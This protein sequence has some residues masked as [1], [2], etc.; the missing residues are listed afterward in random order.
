MKKTGLLFLALVLMTAADVVA[1]NPEYISPMHPW[2]TSDE[3]GQ[4][5]ICGMDLV[6]YDQFESGG[7]GSIIEIDPVVVQNLGVRLATAVRGDLQ[8]N[9]RTVGIV[10]YEE[11]GQTSVNSKISGWVEELHVSQTGQ[12]IRKGELLL[13]IYSPDLVSAQEEYLMAVRNYERL[14]HSSVTG[15]AE[16]AE[17]LLASAAQRLRYWDIS[18]QDIE[19]LRRSKQVRKTLPLYAPYDG[20]VVKK[21]VTQ[22]MFINAGTE[23]YQ[24]ADLSRVWVYADIYEHDL[25]WIAQGMAAEV[26]IPHRQQ[27]LPGT[28]DLLYPYADG[29]TRT[30]KAR[31]ALA[32]SDRALRPDMFVTVRLQ[33]RTVRNAVLVPT[34]AIL[35]SGEQQRVFV[36]LGDGRF[37][38]RPVHTG[39]RGSDGLVEVHGIDAGEQVVVSAQFMLDSESRLREAI[40]KMRTPKKAEPSLDDLFE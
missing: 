16:S 28:V 38:P 8:S 4:C 6:P 20:V 11:T 7:S 27:R 24:L 14:Q 1:D 37:E 21:M 17:R 15:V 36:A 34:E 10:G 9:I 35:D 2:I 40:E 30:V 33:G 29:K 25:P 23:L 32:N 22:G 5:P 31:I 13:S 19:A 3:P 18:Q 12:E 39:L 26:E